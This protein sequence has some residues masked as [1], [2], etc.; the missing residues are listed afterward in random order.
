MHIII[1]DRSTT[2]QRPTAKSPS[3]ATEASP[4]QPS[5][6][7]P[8][9]RPLPSHS[10]ILPIP[11]PSL[12][13]MVSC[14]MIVPP[15]FVR[16]CIWILRLR[17]WDMILRICCF[18]RRVGRLLPRW[19]SYNNERIVFVC[20]LYIREIVHS[21]LHP[22]HCL[23]SKCFLRNV[24]LSH[25]VWDIFLY[26]IL[27]D[28]DPGAAEQFYVA[29][30]CNDEG[31]KQQYHDQYFQY[32]LD[33]LKQHVY[34]ILQDVEQLTMKAQSYDLQTHPRVPVIV[35]HNQLVSQTFTMTAAL[36]EQMG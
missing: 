17:N 23:Y 4:L 12:P 33:A 19:V 24:S 18:R 21:I 8:P 22:I 1:N 32:T 14:P 25:Q 7:S 29:C 30:K 2:A 16:P 27:Q 31:S 13:S 34:G 26:K 36:L 3:V 5:T 35:A 15:S 11:R 10:V 9:D 28:N 6:T 20:I